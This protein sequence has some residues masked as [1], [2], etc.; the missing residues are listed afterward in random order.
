MKNNFRNNFPKNIPEISKKDKVIFDDFMKVWHQEL[1]TKKKF[2]LIESFNH[3]YSAKSHFLKNFDKKINTLELGCGIGTHLNYEDLKNQNYY[4]A[5][6]RKNMLDEIKKKNQDINI[7]ECDIQKKM[8]FNDGFFDRINAIHVLEHLPNLPLC[9]DEVHRLLQ[10]NG[11][12]QVVIPCDPGFFYEICRNISAKRIFEKKY[13]RSYKPFIKREHIN[14]P[15]EIFGLI[16]EKFDIKNQKFF[17]FKIPF[18]NLNLCIGMTCSKK[19][20]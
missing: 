11:I 1:N 2:N 19:I 18:I 13:N 5:D 9:I 17:P 6:I 8:D 14:T 4:V 7:I 16:G 15:E 3:N 20:L 10:N 12:F